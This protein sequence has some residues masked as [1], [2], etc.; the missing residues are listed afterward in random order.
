MRALGWLLFVF[1]PLSVA[2]LLALFV[3]FGMENEAA[4]MAVQA[5]TSA[6]AARAR[7]FAKRAIKQV[8]NAKQATVLSVSERDL[9]SS[10]ALMN[11][12]V[13]R[14]KGDA[15]VTPRGLNA[16]ITFALPKNPIRSY[17]NIRFGIL[18]STK[19]L[20]VSKVSVGAIEL[21]GATAS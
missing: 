18:Q 20:N 7:G 13:R 11:R 14:F 15:K 2:V 1:L 6:D 19:G 12:A 3:V 9:D 16:A 4:V 17:V 21:S 5:P 8:V 10:F